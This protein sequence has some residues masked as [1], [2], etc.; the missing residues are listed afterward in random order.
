MHSNTI[1]VLRATALTASHA[2]TSKLSDFSGAWRALP[3]AE[4]N[5][6][7]STAGIFA[8]VVFILV[9]TEP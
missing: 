5:E 3:E 2:L 1:Q 4:R 7:I 9:T 6:I 8:L